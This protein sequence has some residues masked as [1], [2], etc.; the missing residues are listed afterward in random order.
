MSAPFACIAVV[1][2]GLEELGAAELDTLGAVA[3]Q[4]LRRAVAFRTDSA[5]LYRL[6]LQARLPF[7]IL[8]ELDR[9][10]CSSPGDL[11]AGVQRAADWGCWLPP[12]RSF[13]VEVSGTVPGLNHSHFTALQVKNALVDWQ[14]QRWGER[15]SIDLEDPDLCLHLHLASAGRG[16]E[17]VLSADG[18]AGSLH[19]RGWRAA[20]GLAPLKEN[21][22]AGLIG[23]TGWDGTVPL[24]DPLC[25]SGTLL[26]EAACMA[27]GFAPGLAGREL[28][29]RR[30]PDFDAALWER[31]WAAAAALARDASAAGTP[32]APIIGMEREALVY[33]Q[34]VANAEA[35]GVAPWLELRHGD[36]RDFVPPPQPGVLVCNP[37]YGER[38]GAGEDLDQLYFDLGAMVKARCSGWTLW[39]LSGNAERTG[40]LRMKASRRIPVSNGG[41]DCRWL[42]Y[43]I[44]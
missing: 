6:H 22:A 19:R 5:G 31:E 38:L 16:S 30:W 8:R 34:A 14:R 1:P 11:Y 33:A 37:P 3:V 17:A 35:A 25:G 32:L 10:P 36:C 21:L 12:Q 15:S 44:R 27:L 26:I 28:A 18:S 42:K 39:L 9:F 43:E 24:A 29:L 23:F 41:I 7:R 13:R 2:P 20:V 40:A 4:P